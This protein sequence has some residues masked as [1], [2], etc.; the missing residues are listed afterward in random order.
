MEYANWLL[1]IT[2]TTG[3]RRTPA[4]F[5]DSCAVPC[6]EEPSPIHPSATRGSPRTRNASAAPTA[7]GRIEGRCE[8]PAKMPTP[9]VTSC[10]RRLESRPFVVP[11]TRPMYWHSTRHGSTPR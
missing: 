9:G 11:P 2:N 3:R 5:I 1:S 4:K 7:T 8:G 6:A 10:V